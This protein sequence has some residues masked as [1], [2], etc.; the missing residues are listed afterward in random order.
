MQIIENTPEREYQQHLDKRELEAIFC[1]LFDKI[2]PLENPKCQHSTTLTF[3][4]NYYIPRLH[5]IQTSFLKERR[6][7]FKNY[8][9]FLCNAIFRWPGIL[10]ITCLSN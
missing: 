10:K 9:S 6:D 7:N 4:P 3:R 1:A 5:H 2:K 8:A